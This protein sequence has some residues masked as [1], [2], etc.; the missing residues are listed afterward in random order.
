MNTL[1]HVDSV[2]R[3]ELLWPRTVPWRVRPTAATGSTDA[4]VD[5]NTPVANMLIQ[6]N[7][8][9]ELRLAIYTNVRQLH[10]RHCHAPRLKDVTVLN[11]HWI[12][13]S[14]SSFISHESS[15]VTY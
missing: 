13:R 14:P 1:L 9:T 11:V 2:R 5:R 12:A 4:G 7:V 15:T 3:P 6:Y 10:L 8:R